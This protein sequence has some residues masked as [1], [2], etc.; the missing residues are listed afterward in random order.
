MSRLEP[1]AAK[2][3]AGYKNCL[4]YKNQIYKELQLVLALSVKE[5]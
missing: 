1:A 4:S 5:C 3:T 2:L